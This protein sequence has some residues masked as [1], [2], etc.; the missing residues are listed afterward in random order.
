MWVRSSPSS[1]PTSPLAFQPTRS[2]SW[3]PC[4]DLEAQH[5]HP[6]PQLPLCLKVCPVPS[7]SFHQPHGARWAPWV[8][9]LLCLDPLPHVLLPY[10]LLS[11]V[12]L[13]ESPSLTA[14]YKVAKTPFPALSIPPFASLL[15]TVPMIFRYIIFSLASFTLPYLNISSMKAG[16]LL[17]WFIPSNRNSTCHKLRMQGVCV[18]WM[19]D[20]LLRVQI[21]EDLEAGGMCGRRRSNA[22][23]EGKSRHGPPPTQSMSRVRPE[24]GRKGPEQGRKGRSRLH[25]GRPI[26]FKLI[27]LG[28]TWRKDHC[29]IWNRSEKLQNLPSYDPAGEAGRVNSGFTGSVGE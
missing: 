26:S 16:T 2:K 10:S 25:L 8:L 12:S 17:H 14:P 5:D 28:N 7:H 3:S 18:E 29:N 27:L 4:H 9:G 19:D 13:R 11:N 23:E 1:T 22:S 6:H 21:L 24:Q 20:S 15:S